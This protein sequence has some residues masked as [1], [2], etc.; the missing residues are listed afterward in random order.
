MVD[1]ASIISGDLRGFD[2]I[3]YVSSENTLLDE[4]ISGVA[5]L[6]SWDMFSMS[7]SN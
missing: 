6:E 2:V 3:Q 7:G 4:I 1:A 5:C